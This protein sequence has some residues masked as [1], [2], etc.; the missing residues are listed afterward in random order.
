MRIISKLAQIDFHLGK[1]GREGNLLVIESHQ[2]SKM[3]SRV[4]VSPQDVIELMKC[5][6]VSSRAIIFIIG[7]PYFLYRWKKHGKDSV[8]KKSYKKEWPTV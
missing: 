8:A 4:Y 2:D 3:P 5:F 6:F 7:M 1:V